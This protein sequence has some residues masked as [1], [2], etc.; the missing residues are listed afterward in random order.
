MARAARYL[1]ARPITA[2]HGAIE[3]TR[4]LLD[5]GADP[6][7]RDDRIRP[8]STAGPSIAVNRGSPTCC[9]VAARRNDGGERRDDPRE[10]YRRHL[11]A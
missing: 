8:P 9:D 11:P 1:F 5:A 6:D 4:M 10:A 2:E 7:I 3:L